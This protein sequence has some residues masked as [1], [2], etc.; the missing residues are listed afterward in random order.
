MSTKSVGPLLT[1]SD[2]PEAPPGESSNP[3]LVSGMD[4]VIHHRCRQNQGRRSHL[5]NKV[6]PA[7]E[8]AHS[9]FC[10][11]L[12]GIEHF[13]QIFI[14]EEYPL[15]RVMSLQV[16]LHLL[17]GGNLSLHVRHDAE[18]RSLPVVLS[19][20]LPIRPGRTPL[21]LACH[22]ERRLSAA[23]EGPSGRRQANV[24][25]GAGTRGTTKV[26]CRGPEGPS[27]AFVPH[28][29]QDDR[30]LRCVC[31]AVRLAS[32]SVHHRNVIPSSQPHAAS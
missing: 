5:S 32:A 25:P 2:A 1:S 22:P 24:E 23:V 21:N 27:T 18:S 11:S 16:G 6:W 29:A 28:S 3:H 31:P 7:S 15:T 12:E 20:S 10:R 19:I 9:F 14:V 30:A 13:D 4:R 26:Q 17:E 8:S